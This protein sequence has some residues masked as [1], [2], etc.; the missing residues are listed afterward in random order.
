M[1]KDNEGGLMKAEVVSAVVRR[2][3]TGEEF[4]GE[5]HPR[6]LVQ[7]QLTIVGELV[8]SHAGLVLGDIPELLEGDE[9]ITVDLTVAV[10]VRVGEGGL[11]ESQQVLRNGAG[12]GDLGGNTGGPVGELSAVDLAIMIDISV[13]HQELEDLL[14]VT[15]GLIVEVVARADAGGGGQLG[16]DR[17]VVL[18]VDNA[19]AVHVISVLEEKVKFGFEKVS[20][21]FC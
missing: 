17:L 11:E 18:K 2:I 16:H 7:F 15:D 4:G 20:H 12:G 3:V 8:E 19:I 14:L 5:S 1:K 21:L 9:L 10:L 6:I 13:V